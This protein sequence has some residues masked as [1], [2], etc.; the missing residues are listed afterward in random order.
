MKNEV[1]DIASK[2]FNYHLTK[3]N[4]YSYLYGEYESTEIPGWVFM[5]VCEDKC[6]IINALYYNKEQNR[7][8]T[9][10]QDVT[11]Y[12][13]FYNTQLKE[14]ENYFIELSAVVKKLTNQMELDKL[15]KDFE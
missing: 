3:H 10:T 5:R 9:A 11:K 13:F 12:M 14:I 7:I 4:S 1:L 6:Y 2:Y 8:C 15:K